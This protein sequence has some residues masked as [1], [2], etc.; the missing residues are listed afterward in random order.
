MDSGGACWEENTNAT[1]GGLSGREVS[2][3]SIVTENPD[4]FIQSSETGVAAVIHVDRTGVLNVASAALSDHSP[5]GPR[6]RNRQKSPSLL[7]LWKS[8]MSQSAETRVAILV[9]TW[10]LTGDWVPV[11]CEAGKFDSIRSEVRQSSS[12]EGGTSSS[13]SDSHRHR[14][15]R[16]HGH[17]GCHECDDDG[18]EFFGKLFFAALTSPFWGP[19][20]ALGDDLS[21]TSYFAEHPYEN[22]KGNMLLEGAA[23]GAHDSQIVLQGQYGDNIGG[24]RHVNGRLLL[25]H[26]SRF[27]VDTEIFYRNEE[28]PTGHDELW[29]GDANLTYRFAQNEHWQ[30]RA[31]LGM[32][33]LADRGSSDTGINFTYGMDW[34]PAEPWRLT[35]LIDWGRIGDASLFHGRTTIGVS[36]NGWGV[37]TGYDY[38]EIGDQDIH[39]WIN[40]VELRF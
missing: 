7:F 35:G 29:T 32:N 25:E 37:F 20:V 6:I 23:R 2:G 31:G 34:F 4:E 9:L 21:T 40:G 3:A 27:G 19:H 24:I 36:H 33:W 38:L 5:A 13:D 17:Y 10:L 39:A 1:A 11:T 22:A 28:I 15:C 12:G 18:N 26:S 16:D 30:F 8:V 14:R